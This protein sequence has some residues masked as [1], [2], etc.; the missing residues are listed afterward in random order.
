MEVGTQGL[1]CTVE[2]VDQHNTS[3]YEEVP[4]L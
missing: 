3:W 2:A 4:V 1:L